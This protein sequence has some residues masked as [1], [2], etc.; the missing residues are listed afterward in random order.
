MNARNLV[1]AMGCAAALA[2][3]PAWAEVKWTFNFNSSTNCLG[4]NAT[5]ACN[6]GNTRHASS[7]SG[8]PLPLPPTTDVTAQAWSNTQGS[9]SGPLQ[10]AY[11]PAWGSNG[12]GVQNRDMANAPS[13]APAGLGDGGDGVEGNS[14]EH[15]MDNNQRYDSILFSFEH[16]VKLTGV[17]IGWSSN[18]SDLFVLAYTGVGSPTLSG[19]NYSQLTAN[20]WDLIGNYFDLATNSKKTVNESGVSA[21]HWLIGTGCYDQNGSGDVSLCSAGNKDYVKLLAVYTTP[22]DN[23]VPEPASALLFA[24][25]G[26]GLWRFR[27]ARR[28]A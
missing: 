18:D 24:I 19:L 26:A 12:L 8:S 22:G 25:A 15:A 23:K 1:W 16:S 4:Q 17:E 11:L 3:A 7:V 27:A 28:G 5:A 13:P 21:N 20:G 2:A 6:F 14:P 9:G 10:T